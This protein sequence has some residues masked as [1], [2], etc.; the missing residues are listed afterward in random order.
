MSLRWKTGGCH[1]GA[2]E[3]QALTNDDIIVHECNC[4][5]CD[6][7]GYLHLIVPAAHFKLIKGEDRLT[8]YKFK[9][10]IAQHKFCKN[11]GVKSFYVPRSN[12]DGF[13][14]NLR[15][16]DRDQFSKITIAPLDGQNWELNAGNLAHLSKQDQ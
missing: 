4:S 13:S 11:C 15:C 7:V 8:S 5:I 12:P 6:M 16:M 9:T 2:V 3:W 1:C 14:L 10:G